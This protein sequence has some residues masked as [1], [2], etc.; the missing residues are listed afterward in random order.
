M[1]RFLYFSPE[2][3]V[4]TDVQQGELTILIHQPGG[5]LWV[6]MS[7]E[8]KQ[9]CKLILENVFKFHPLAVDDALEQTHIPKIDDWGKYLYMVLYEISSDA[10]DQELARQHELDIFL[11][12][13][14]LVTY[15]QKKLSS[16]EHVWQSCQR[17][18]RYLKRG[19]PYLFYQLADEMVSHHFPVFD[20]I[21]VQIDQLE[22]QILRKPQKDTL[23]SIF[24][25]KRALLRLRRLM[26]PQQ[27]VFN[28]LS[29]NNFLVLTEEQKHFFRDVFDH[30]V[31]F[32]ELAESQREMVASSLET[33]LSAI[34]NR[35]NEVVKTLTVITT[36]FMPITFVSTFFGMNFFQREVSFEMWSGRLLFGVAIGLMVIIP[37]FMFFWMRKKDWT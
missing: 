28:R 26:M 14:F 27:E 10:L 19:A 33:Y 1:I 8:D 18:P 9:K 29:R 20:Q 23:E 22:D 24:S 15:H 2:G 4:R 37:T 25:L 21:E 17:D 11:G 30:Y 32:H 5:V 12:E 34:N 36:M 31:H 6:D 35:M 7:G 13:G 16:L 3:E